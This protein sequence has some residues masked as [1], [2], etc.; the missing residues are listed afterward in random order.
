MEGAL[1]EGIVAVLTHCYLIATLV[2]YTIMFIFPNMI[3][4]VYPW[5][6]QRENDTLYFVLHIHCHLHDQSLKCG[7]MQA[8]SIIASHSSYHRC[9]NYISHLASQFRMLEFLL[10]IA[11]LRIMVYRNLQLVS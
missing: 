6:L 2:E 8:N 1:R 9:F 11:N 5:S 7:E 4:R 10:N 3:A